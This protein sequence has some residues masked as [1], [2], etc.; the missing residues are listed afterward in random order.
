[1]AAPVDSARQGTNITT[2]GTSHAINVGSPVSGTL[3]VVLCRFAA[4]PGT[5][6]FTGYT[7]IASDTSDATDDTTQIFYRLADGTEG[8][9]D[10][11]S[12][13]NSVKMCAICWE[14]TGAEDPSRSAPAV[15]TVAVG[16][17][18][19]DSANPDIRAPIVAPQDTLY[20]A[21]M[22]LDGEGNAPTVAP[23]NFSNLQTANSGTAGSVA[24]NCS[25]G[26]ASRQ[27]TASSSEDPGTFTHGAAANGWTAYTVAIR[28]PNL[29]ADDANRVVT[30]TGGSNTT[31]PAFNVPS[32]VVTGELLLLAWRSSGNVT[33]ITDAA[34]FTQL[35]LSSADATD[36]DFYVGYKVADGT[37][38]STI[39]FTVSNGRKFAAIMWRIDNGGTPMISSVGTSSGTSIDP[40][41]YNPGVGEINGLWI[42]IA[43]CEDTRT[44]SAFPSPYVNTV[45]ENVSTGADGATVMAGSRQ[46]ATS[47]VNPNPFTLNS[48]SNNHMHATVA[49]TYEADSAGPST[50]FP[51]VILL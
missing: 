12:T 21:M 32:G 10:T 46:V 27:L 5:V 51:R 3:L 4:A 42:P 44:V 23:S 33:S 43:T 48:I 24:T 14:I 11:L 25:I 16:T 38:G 13:T 18:A 28:E 34:G 39:T 26:G 47:Q 50:F 45:E 20:L 8:A 29:F 1:M 22:G 30:D 37:E 7:S 31:T 19:A 9:T 6:T 35:S 17:T 41:T 15:S 40:A 36:D 49:I 2:A